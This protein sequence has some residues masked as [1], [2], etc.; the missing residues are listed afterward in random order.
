MENILMW[1]QNSRNRLYFTRRPDKYAFI[2]RPEEFLLTEKNIDSFTAA[3]AA[4]P[5][6]KKRIVKVSCFFFFLSF[7]CCVPILVRETLKTF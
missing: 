6:T 7:Q 4:L 5:E 1:M 3:E 2:D